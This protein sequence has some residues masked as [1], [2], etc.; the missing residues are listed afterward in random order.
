MIPR[1]LVHSATQ[2]LPQLAETGSTAQLLLGIGA[3]A[4][5]IG[6]LLVFFKNKG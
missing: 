5:L 1:D 2:A 3:V 4:L 6:A